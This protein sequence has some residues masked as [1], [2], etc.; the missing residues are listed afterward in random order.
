MS[1]VSFEDIRAVERQVETV[2]NDLRDLDREVDQ[3]R[4][5][6]HE[7]QTKLH[8]LEAA[9]YE[10]YKNESYSHEIRDFARFLYGVL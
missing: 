3:V 5:E 7:C 10:A 2:T 8:R 4:D 1:D 6:S 9:L